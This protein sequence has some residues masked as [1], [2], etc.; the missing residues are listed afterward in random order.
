MLSRWLW[1]LLVVAGC[2]TDS[3]PPPAVTPPPMPT[4]PSVAAPRT[5]TWR[6]PPHQRSRRRGNTIAM[7][8]VTRFH[9]DGTSVTVELLT[10]KAWMWRRP[11]DIYRLEARW[12]G[13]ELQYRP[14]FG[15][16]TT[17]ATFAADHYELADADAEPAWVFEPVGDAIKDADDRKLDAPRPLHDYSIKPMDPYRP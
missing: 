2:W 13:S 17:L 10:E 11:D 5:G 1:S 4:K 7:P 6:I 8:G 14:P 12:I 9:Y 3:A 16:W 15:A